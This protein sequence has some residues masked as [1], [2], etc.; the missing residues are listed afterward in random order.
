MG[1]TFTLQ[2]KG[3]D[4]SHKSFFFF[5]GHILSIDFFSHC[6]PQIL[7]IISRVFISVLSVD[8]HPSHYTEYNLPN[9]VIYPK[10]INHVINWLIKDINLHMDKLI[11]ISEKVPITKLII[12]CVVVVFF[13]LILCQFLVWKLYTTTLS[14]CYVIRHTFNHI[15]STKHLRILFP[16]IGDPE[17]DPL[18]S[19]Y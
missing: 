17:A 12:G 18:T 7:S 5:L 13:R 16:L 15:C 19:L 9:Q 3:I 1:L 11:L 10:Y 8:L 4:F 6:S 2:T 14:F